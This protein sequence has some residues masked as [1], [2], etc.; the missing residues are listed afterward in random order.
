MIFYSNKDITLLNFRMNLN[1][2]IFITI[3]DGIGYKIRYN[4]YG[5]LLVSKNFR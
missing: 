4:P 3:S 2:G 1:C 5:L